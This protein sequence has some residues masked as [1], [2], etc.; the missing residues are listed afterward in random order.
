[1][2]YSEL[3]HLIIPTSTFSAMYLYMYF[4][5]SCDLIGYYELEGNK[6]T[7]LM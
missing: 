6:M 3:T 2:N 5:K 1:M 4:I 7:C